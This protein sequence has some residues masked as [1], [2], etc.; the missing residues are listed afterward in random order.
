MY[1]DHHIVILPSF[2]KNVLYALRSAH[3][4]VS[5]MK[6]RAN[7]TIYWPEMINNIRSTGITVNIVMKLHHVNPGSP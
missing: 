6:A 1:I 3:Q 7:A 4:G 5:G 2:Q